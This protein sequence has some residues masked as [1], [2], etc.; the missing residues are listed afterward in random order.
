MGTMRQSCLSSVYE[1]KDSSGR[2]VYKIQAPCYAPCAP[3]VFWCCKENFELCMDDGVTEIG[4][5]T[6]KWGRSVDV[7]EFRNCT[8]IEM[9]RVDDV[10]VKALLLG[11]FFLIEFQ[12]FRRGGNGP[13]YFLVLLLIFGAIIVALE[14]GGYCPVWMDRVFTKIDVIR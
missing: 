3:F 13:F 9:E 12:Y 6:N 11:C 8:G 14:C 7:S 2:L 1:I 5:I 4:R 10:R